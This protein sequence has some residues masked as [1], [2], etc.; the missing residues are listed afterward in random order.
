MIGIPKYVELVIDKL[1]SSNYE[2]FLVGGS[3]RDLILGKSPNDFDITTNAIPDEIEEVFGEYKTLSIGK[4]FGTVAVVQDEGT[5]EITTY[6]SEGEYIDGRRPSEVFF[7][8]DIIEDLSRRDFTI[9]AMAYNKK[10][11]IIDPFGGRHDIGKQIIKTV[12]N[13]IERFEEDHLRVLRGIRF[14]TQLKFRMD[15]ETLMA[16][17]EKASSLR[18]ISAERIRE[19]LFKI[20]L[21]Q[22]PSVGI[23]LL[24]KT[25]VLDVIL[26]ELLETVDFDQKNPNHDKDVFQH[27][28]CVL[29]NTSSIIPLRLAALFHDIGKPRSFTVDD[30]GIGHFYGHDKLGMEITKEILI[31]L[32]VSNELIDKVTILIKEHM[33]HHNEMKDKALKRLIAR[34]GED[35]IFNLFELQKSDRLCSS[36]TNNDIESILEREKQIRDIIDYREPY[37]KS[38]LNIDGNDIINL[39]YQ[40]GKLIGEIL[41]YLMNQVLENPNINEKNMLK[42]IVIEKFGK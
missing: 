10:T 6:R 27:S 34:V 3:L 25:N 20:L 36:A 4:R 39:G 37:K 31:R 16:C 18:D 38:Q 17:K 40:Q 28:L 7:S 15:E 2:A 32:K 19:E 11:G 26:P 21:S 29:D 33:C 5:I 24:Q 42:E 9:N 23:R 12:G 1:E 41:D 13:P 22:V 35:D 30:D 8:K 14:A